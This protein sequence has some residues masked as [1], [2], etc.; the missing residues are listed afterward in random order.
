MKSTLFASLLILGCLFVIPAGA[1]QLVWEQKYNGMPNT[2]NYQRH[3]TQV[4]EL[5]DSTILLLGH[6]NEYMDMKKLNKNGGIIWTKYLRI[7]G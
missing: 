2:A 6:G 5:S 1:Q 7:S 3:P 4:M